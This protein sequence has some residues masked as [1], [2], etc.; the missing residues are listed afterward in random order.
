MR[1][2]LQEVN[3]VADEDLLDCEL[4]K[5]LYVLD[6]QRV[7]VVGRLQVKYAE[8]RFL[9]GICKVA[10]DLL[11]DLRANLVYATINDVDTYLAPDDSGK[12]GSG[13]AYKLDPC[14]LGDTLAIP[15]GVRV[16]DRVE[17]DQPRSSNGL[18]LLLGL[19]LVNDKAPCH[20]YHVLAVDHRAR[21]EA[22]DIILNVL[23]VE[24][25]H[26]LHQQRDVVVVELFR[27]GDEDVIAVLVHL[28]NGI[29]VDEHLGGFPT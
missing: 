2:P 7:G 17:E 9:C 23:N 21:R 10:V 18:Q 4:L 15:T 19:D 26:H 29:G 27:R 11:G 6:V 25:S 13:A 8:T 28:V 20:V 1:A 5:N 22:G 14:G 12:R 24:A 3:R 16:L